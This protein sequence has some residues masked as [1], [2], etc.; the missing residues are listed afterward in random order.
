MIHQRVATIANENLADVSSKLF[1][2]VS[3]ILL[4]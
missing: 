2:Q 3:K 4:S 1:R